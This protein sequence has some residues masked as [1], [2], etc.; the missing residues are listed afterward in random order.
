MSLRQ[1][2][3]RARCTPT[4]LI[5]CIRSR[6]PWRTGTLENAA[7]EI[8]R[9]LV[10]DARL[11]ALISN[12]GVA[13]PALFQCQPLDHVRRQIGVNVIG[14]FSDAAAAFRT[15]LFEQACSTALGELLP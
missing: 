2:A 9:R 13:L 15:R 10:G 12:A 3:M 1:N 14:A 11:Y 8:V 7:R 4:G 5:G 6:L